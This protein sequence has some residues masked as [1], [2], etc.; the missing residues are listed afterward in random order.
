MF[1]F[2]YFISNLYW[3]TN[4]LTFDENF[5]PLIPIA[6]ISIPLFLGIFYGIAT[7]I[8]SFFN[9]KENFS[10]IIIFSLAFSIIEYL[11]SF[12][13]VDFLGI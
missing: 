11:S 1:G 6:I 4:S 7:L 12:I 9:P 13:M 5:K 3:I 8:I 2:G 10:S